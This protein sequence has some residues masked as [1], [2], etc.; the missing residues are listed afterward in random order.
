M[1]NTRGSRKKKSPDLDGSTFTPPCPHSQPLFLAA[2]GL[3]TL[4][5]IIN[6]VLCAAGITEPSWKASFPPIAQLESYRVTKGTQALYLGNKPQGGTSCLA[7]PQSH[8]LT[9]RSEYYVLTY[10]AYL[11][12]IW[13]FSIF[14]LPP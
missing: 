10:P 1:I 13:S 14:S 4:V 7:S 11:F 3:L 9:L 8:T 6:N 12:S 2:F 5:R